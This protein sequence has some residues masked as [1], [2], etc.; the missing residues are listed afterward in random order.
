ME[1][2]LGQWFELAVVFIRKLLPLGLTVEQVKNLIENRNHPFWI[3]FEQAKKL[4]ETPTL[5]NRVSVVKQNTEEQI[6]AWEKFYSQFFSVDVKFDRALIPTRIAGSDRLILIPLGLRLN[7]AFAACQKHFKCWK[8]MD[9]D[10]ESKMQESERGPARQATA[11]WF[12]ERVEAD[13]G[14][15]SKSA[16]DLENEEI[17]GITLLERIVYE[18]KYW[19][20][21]KK[22]LDIKSVTLCSGSRYRSGYVPSVDW[23]SDDDSVRVGWGYSHIRDPNLRC[24][25]AVG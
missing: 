20:E 16:F 23:C 17:Q 4:L 6:V 14:T 22:H 12:R 19:S 7:I 1:V 11:R 15:Q 2:L 18:L 3:A 25:V 24:R 10:I 21:T 5:E 8:W 9:G 13:E